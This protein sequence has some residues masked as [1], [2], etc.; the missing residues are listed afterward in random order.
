ME[1]FQWVRLV[2]FAV[3]HVCT[4]SKLNRICHRCIIAGLH[5]QSDRSP[6]EPLNEVQC[7]GMHLT[8]NCHLS[9]TW[10]NIQHTYSVET[11]WCSK[12][13]PAAQFQDMCAH[14]RSSLYC[15]VRKQTWFRQPANP[16]FNWLNL[17]NRNLIIQSTSLVRRCVILLFSL[18]C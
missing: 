8:T 6:F 11:S 12:V 18:Y 4:G 5:M 10:L 15:W 1:G 13:L 3:T 9:E 17:P 7:K 14:A 2:S 16:K